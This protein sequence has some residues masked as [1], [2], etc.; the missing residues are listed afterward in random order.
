MSAAFRNAV[1]KATRGHFASVDEW[2]TWRISRSRE[3][4]LSLNSEAS[5]VEV[6]FAGMDSMNSE[7]SR[8]R[9][10][11]LEMH[12]VR[13]DDLVNC[14]SLIFKLDCREVSCSLL[15]NQSS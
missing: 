12:S 14:R 15:R 2:I 8:S 4:N 6:S 11:I 1:M 3:S 7:S 13:A 5:S 10:Q 9:S